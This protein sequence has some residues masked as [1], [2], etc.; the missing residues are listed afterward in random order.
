MHVHTYQQQKSIVDLP[1]QVQLKT[2][3]EKE[4]AAF[5]IIILAHH[6]YFL[7]QPSPVYGTQSIPV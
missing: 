1:L 2:E 6:T 7:S 5:V 4:T 3:R